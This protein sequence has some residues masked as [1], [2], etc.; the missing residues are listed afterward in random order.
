MNNNQELTP[1][2]IKRLE[3][4]QAQVTQ[5]RFEKKCEYIDYTPEILPPKK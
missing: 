4:I 3:R 2:E 1:Q 5:K